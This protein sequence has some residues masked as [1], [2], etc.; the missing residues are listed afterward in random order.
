MPLTEWPWCNAATL[1]QAAPPT[2]PHIQTGPH[3]SAFVPQRGD[4]MLGG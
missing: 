4:E 3:R 2:L 1:E